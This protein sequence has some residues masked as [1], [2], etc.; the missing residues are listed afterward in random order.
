MRL[1]GLDI[2][3][4]VAFVGMVLVNFRLAADVS[5][6]GSF[7]S[8]F[9]DHIEGRASALFVVL[10]GIGFSLGKPDVMVTYKRAAFLFVIG[11]IDMMIFSADILHFYAMY[12]LV[13][14]FALRFEIRG[15][16]YLGLGI[17]TLWF[18][19]LVYVD[20]DRGW[21]WETLSYADFWT[22]FGF[23]RNSLYNGW[24][25]VAPWATFF[26][27]GMALGRVDLTTRTTHRRMAIGGGL[28]ALV[29]YS[30]SWMGQSAIAE[31]AEIL[32]LHSI[33]PG[34]LYVLFSTCT[35]MSAIGIILMITPALTRLKITPLLV[36]PGRQTLTLYAA[37]I[38]LGMGTL[39]GLGLLDG[40]LTNPEI[41][42]ISLLFC[43]LTMIYAR[44]WALFSKRG[45]LE[46]IMRR[47]SG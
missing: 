6:D 30:L 29:F 12:F 46:W 31:F 23:I 37:H 10:A 19:M 44:L 42:K 16:I 14:I 33:P 2:A 7:V 3:R 11:M 4:F 22:P 18:L 8:F 41:F 5:A 26:V 32:T 21:D 27:F 20:Y 1:Q 45:P 24:H 38:L 25:P 28:S 13:G 17:I 9:I 36:A 34:P 47:V 15:L 35:A 43:L 40:S 39:E